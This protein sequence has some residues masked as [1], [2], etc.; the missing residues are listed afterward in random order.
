MVKVADIRQARH[1]VTER[2]DLLSDIL[3]RL[4]TVELL[5][6][7]ALHRGRQDVHKHRPHDVFAQLLI[8]IPRQLCYLVLPLL[9]TKEDIF[10]L[11]FDL[12]LDDLQ[13]K[14]HH[15]L[16][17]LRIKQFV[18]L[19]PSLDTVIVPNTVHDVVGI[20]GSAVAQPDVHID[21]LLL[22]G[23]VALPNRADLLLLPFEGFEKVREVVIAL[24]HGI[25][26]V[27]HPFLEL[28]VITLELATIMKGLHIQSTA[29]HLMVGILLI[30][31]DHL[32]EGIGS[33]LLHQLWLL[34]LLQKGHE[35]THHILRRP[36]LLLRSR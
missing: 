2:Y 31:R 29:C 30:G 23:K 4:E 27:A 18:Q 9:Q 11:A 34:L 12:P 7:P 19:T 17:C 28:R 33:F 3:V 13:D 15:P 5:A 25:E 26:E 36:L 24:L 16:V 8:V 14:C 1:D 20:S 32:H 21:A 6:N 10:V 35:H 22:L